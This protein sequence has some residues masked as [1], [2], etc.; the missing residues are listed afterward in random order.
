MNLVLSG[1]LAVGAALS[2]W[3]ACAL[4]DA[5]GGPAAGSSSRPN[6]AG[7]P[8]DAADQAEVRRR[9]TAA[10][11]WLLAALLAAS[12]WGITMRLEPAP[13]AAAACWLTICGVPLAVIDVRVRRLPN[14]LTAA[15]LAGVVSLLVVAAI[16][17][18]YRPELLV[19]MAGGLA[20]GGL[21]G[22]LAL[23]RPGSA[24]LGDAKLGLSTGALAGWVGWSAVLVSVIAAFAFAAACG[25]LLV[26][27]RR[28]TLRG[29]SLPFGPFLLAGCL[30]VVLLAGVG[31]GDHVAA[32]L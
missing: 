14:G 1:S 27:T 25:L 26:V 28:A 29:T 12:A 23:A 2:A 30:T 32:L 4:I 16:A 3:P 20:V 11:R 17:T 13:V 31:H 15:S 6:G 19:A 8:A 22:L 21:F 5:A 9:G 18:G 10:R 7:S 24:G